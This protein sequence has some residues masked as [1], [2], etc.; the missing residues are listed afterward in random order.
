MKDKRMQH[1]L[2]LGSVFTLFPDGP[3]HS[4]RAHMPQELRDRVE[5]RMRRDGILPR[6]SVDQIIR[7]AK[8]QASISNPDA[9]VDAIVAAARRKVRSFSSCL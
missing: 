7:R 2:D 5:K 8:T 1:Q 3:P 4:V 9:I 6:L